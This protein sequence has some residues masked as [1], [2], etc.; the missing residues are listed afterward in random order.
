[1]EKWTLKQHYHLL[2]RSWGFFVHYPNNVLDSKRRSKI[3]YCIQLS[4]LFSLYNLQ[5]FLFLFFCIY[6]T[7]IFEEYRLVILE[8]IPQFEFVQCFLIMGFKL[9]F[10]VGILCKWCWVVTPWYQVAH[11]VDQCHFWKC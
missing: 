5:Q 11:A 2:Y 7:D 3:M 4:C 9:Q 1:M 6:D 10:L 8:N